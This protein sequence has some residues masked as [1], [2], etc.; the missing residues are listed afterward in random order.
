KGDAGVSVEEV[1]IQYSKGT[2]PTTAPTT[3]WESS[4]PPYQEGYY[5]WSRTRIKYSNSANYVYSVPV[6]DQSWKANAEVYTQYKQLKDKFSW[7][8]KNGDNASNM[9]LTDKMYSLVTTNVLIE[10]KKIEL[11][12][13]ID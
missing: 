2:S 8:V 9:E 12:G 1:I 11:N 6:C 10:A 7:I 3:G 5:L 13:S 4:M